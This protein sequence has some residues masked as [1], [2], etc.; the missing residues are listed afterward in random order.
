MAGFIGMWIYDRLQTLL[1]GNKTRFKDDYLPFHFGQ[2]ISM[3]VHL[4]SLGNHIRSLCLRLLV[5]VRSKQMASPWSKKREGCKQ[6][7]RE[8]FHHRLWVVFGS[9]SQG[10]CFAFSSL[11]PREGREVAASTDY[12]LS[13]ATAVDMHWR[14][15]AGGRAWQTWIKPSRSVVDRGV[16]NLSADTSVPE[17]VL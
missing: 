7:W 1:F 15:P 11:W 14:G 5:T 6:T 13:A 12:L 9:H 2:L 16:W 4:T 17:L 10:S 8:L 3:I